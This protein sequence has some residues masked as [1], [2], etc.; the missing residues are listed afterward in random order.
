[1]FSQVNFS[2]TRLYLMI[3]NHIWLKRHKLLLVSAT[4]GTL[5]ILIFGMAASQRTGRMLH[6]VL[7]PLF[8]FG[9]G[10]I[11]TARA[12]PELD[13][14]KTSG[15]W[16]MIPA[17]TFE[18]FCSRLFLTSFGYVAGSIVV[19]FIVTMI[20]KGLN[21]MIFEFSHP[22]FNPLDPWVRYNIALYLVL[23][24]MFLVGAIY[25][26]RFAFVK[27][28]LFLSLLSLVFLVGFLVMSKWILGD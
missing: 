15:P 12:F 8:L 13:D 2:P 17:S 27:T 16:L 23:Q 7:Y 4:A 24:S 22:V 14:V 25:F 3:R 9:S 20:S 26:R 6:M 19:Y 21:Q 5:V 10:F 28:I 11:V 18:K 1:M